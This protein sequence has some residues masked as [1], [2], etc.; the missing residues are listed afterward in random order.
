MSQKILDW[1]HNN[2]LLVIL[3]C[4]ALGAFAP[5]LGLAVSKIHFGIIGQGEDAL[6]ISIPF[7]MLSL[8][9]FNSGL[10]IKQNELVNLQHHPWTLFWGFA[11]NF[12]LPL[13][14]ILFLS[15]SMQWWHNPD[16]LQ[17][18]LAGLALVGAMPIAAS[19]TA[20]TQ[21]GNGNLALSLGLILISTLLSPVTTPMALHFSGNLTTGDYSEDLHLLANG[22]ANLFLILSVVIP[23]FA[24]IA[25][26]FLIKEKKASDLRSGLK[27]TNLLILLLLNYF[28]ASN[29]LPGIIK[30]PDWD[31]LLMIVVVTF[32]LCVTAFG[33][34]YLTGKFLK[35][36]KADR[37]SLMFGLGMNNNGTG[38]V[39]ASMTLSDHP[40]VM[41]PIIIYN[42]LQHI[43]AGLVDKYNERN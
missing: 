17:N 1:I 40:L 35:V 42:L 14:I 37:T 8:L 16:E 27:E 3:G 33:V 6:K 24:G 22:N 34:G 18:V 30:N 31:F 13:S 43:I 25:L 4:Y 21:K 41:L 12:C 15:I 7:L 38:L 36:N 28:N 11:L 10:G 2:F 5:F 23:S 29:V 39:L 26:H 20:W 19:S 32:L 9:L